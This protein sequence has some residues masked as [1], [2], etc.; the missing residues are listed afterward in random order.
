MAIL[1]LNARADLVPFHAFRQ[2][3]LQTS[4]GLGLGTRLRLDRQLL[5][6]PFLDVASLVSNGGEQGLLSLAFDP[7]YGSNGRFYISYTNQAGDTRV[8]RYRVSADPD[9]ADP[10]TAEVILAV[11][12]PYSNHNGGLV[13]FGPDGMLYVGLGDGGSGGDPDDHGQNLGTLLGK[14]LRIDVSGGGGYVVPPDNPFLSD[15][16][17]RDEIWAYGLRNPWRFS[18]DSATGDLWIG[19][20]GQ[21]AWEE[22]DLIVKGGNYGWNIREGAHP[23]REGTSVDELIDPVAEYPQRRGQPV[24]RTKTVGQPTVSDSPC[25]E[26]KISVIRRRSSVGDDSML[27]MDS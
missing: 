5:P 2:G 26:R 8:V 21:N 24:R 4:L 16:A 9:R 11:D 6:V 20:V 12:Q 18:F 23:F 1:E 7:D 10:A 14:L 17:A 13:T 27:F 19:D 22:I 25:R 15:P 3:V